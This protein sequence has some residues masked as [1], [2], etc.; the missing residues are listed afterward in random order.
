M[1][2]IILFILLLSVIICIHEWGHLMAAKLFHVYCFEY[3]FGMGP[4]Q[5]GRAHV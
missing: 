5:I 3:S 4:V 2:T 1:L